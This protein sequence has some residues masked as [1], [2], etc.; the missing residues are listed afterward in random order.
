MIE[1]IR[2]R[3]QLL[4]FVERTGLTRWHEPDEQ[5]VD[6]V[7][8]VGWRFGSAYCDPEAFRLMTLGA[9]S[10]DRAGRIDSGGTWAV[11]LPGGR[12]EHGVFLFHDGV[13]VA[14]VNL[15]MLFAFA[16]GMTE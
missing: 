9:E 16:S 4:A 2:T 8:A 6:A 7:P 3:E 1:N 13:P 12:A 15:A 10:S 11:R 5:G 14:F